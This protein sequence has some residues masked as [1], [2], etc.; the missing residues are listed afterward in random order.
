M[1]KLTVRLTLALGDNSICTIYYYASYKYM[2]YA[3]ITLISRGRLMFV[4]QIQFEL[5]TEM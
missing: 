1:N 3:A 5:K 2:I 4:H